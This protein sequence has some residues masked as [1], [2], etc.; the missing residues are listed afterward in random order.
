MKGSATPKDIFF[1][2]GHVNGYQIMTEINQTESSIIYTV[3]TPQS[4]LYIAKIMI[5]NSP[6]DFSMDRVFM[7]EA[8]A[9][10]ILNHPSI[11]KVRDFFVTKMFYVIIYDYYPEGSLKDLLKMTPS[12]SRDNM[13]KIFFSL[14]LGVQYC[15]NRNIALKNIKPSNILLNGMNAIVSDVAMKSIDRPL[16]ERASMIPYLAPEVFSGKPYNEKAADIWS[17]GVVL[18]QALSG[19]LPWTATNLDEMISQIKIGYFICS[20]KVDVRARDLISKMMELSPL[21]RISSHEIIA[22][23]WLLSAKAKINKLGQG[24][25]SVAQSLADLHLKPSLTFP[26]NLDE[27]FKRPFGDQ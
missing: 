25:V 26:D 22:H 1:P 15:H 20:S 16:T 18:Y 23:P 27:M 2:D 21:K 7:T 3:R 9:L 8:N 5:K 10:T 4:E 14:M 11:A 12:V 13:Q 19:K 6:D 17:L 24:K